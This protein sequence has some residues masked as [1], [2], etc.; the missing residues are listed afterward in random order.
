MSSGKRKGRFLL[1]AG[2]LATAGA[3][4][5]LACSSTPTVDDKYDPIAKAPRKSDGTP[6]DQ[7]SIMCYQLPGSITKDGQPILGGTDINA[8]DATFAG[9][10]YPKLGGIFGQQAAPTAG[11][12]N[13]DE[14]WG[15]AEDPDPEQTLAA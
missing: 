4:A 14:D 6:P 12:A 7:T 13:L 5:V 15:E 8:T 11:A 9:G 2:V 3:L 10:I 1:L